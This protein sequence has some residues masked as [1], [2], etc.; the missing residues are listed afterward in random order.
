[1]EFHHI[2]IATNDA[3]GTAERYKSVFG[4]PICHHQRLDEVEVT[5][6]E[7][8][9][10]FL[11]LVEP[12]T[13]GSI[14]QYLDEQGPGLHHIAFETDDIQAALQRAAAADVELIDSEPRSGAWGHSIAFL[15]PHSLDGVLVEF[16]QLE[17]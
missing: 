12:I 9:T 11:E 2:G 13:D 1:M 8:A 6:L 4:I 3:A 5:F 14:Q 15:H 7:L 16:V 10:G 17:S